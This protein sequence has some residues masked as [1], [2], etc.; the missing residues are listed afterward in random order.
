MTE[1]APTAETPPRA[2][3]VISEPDYEAD[4]LNPELAIS[5]WQ[6]HRDF[7]YDLIAFVQPRLIVELGVHY[8]CSYFAF[9]QAV[10]DRAL[11]AQVVGIDTWKGDPH[12]GHY[13][14]EVFELIQKTK[15]FC[16]AD[17]RFMV[18]R[19]SFDDAVGEFTD[20]SIDLLHI[21]GLH[22]Y[23]AVSR[24]F[25]TWLPKLARDGIILLHDV[26]PS[27]GYES[28]RF[29]AETRQRYPHFE[30]LNQ[31]GLGIVF[32]KGDRWF[33]AG[34]AQG[35]PDKIRGYRYRGEWLASGRR[36]AID[37]QW[38]KEQTDRWWQESEKLKLRI[39]E[40][41]KWRRIASVGAV[42]IVRRTD[43]D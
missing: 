38:Q 10:K 35:L 17:D 33:R 2:A 8:G 27:S 7:A 20:G 14:E 39:A 15:A 41:E 43:R 16:F 9:C 13:G 18:R 29:W 42:G 36:A 24:D 34:L 1:D 28:A 4:A 37:L 23:D 31:W 32:P 12:A 30:F 22:T 26:A 19:A 40:L 5:P 21:D 25:A 3:W 6:S 11:E